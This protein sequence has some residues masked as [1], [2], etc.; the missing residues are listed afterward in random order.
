MYSTKLTIPVL[1]R[2]EGEKIMRIGYL[3]IFTTFLI[4]EKI[5]SYGYGVA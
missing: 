1:Y 4:Q 5:Y 2:R 3:L